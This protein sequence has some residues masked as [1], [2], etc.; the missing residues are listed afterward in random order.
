MASNKV[1]L[2]FS[3]S[4]GVS[5][6]SKTEDRT[7]VPAFLECIITWGSGGTKVVFKTICCV[8]QGIMGENI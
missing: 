4:T 8:P 2:L 6:D 5:S 7:S 1:H 3:G